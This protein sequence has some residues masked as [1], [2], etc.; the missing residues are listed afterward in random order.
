MEKLRRSQAFGLA[1]AGFEKIFV[2]GDNRV[3][4]RVDCRS[5]DRTIVHVPDGAFFR[6]AFL[7]IRRP[8]DFH[9]K[10]QTGDEPLKVVKPM[11]KF[12]IETRRISSRE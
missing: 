8:H 2:A 4:V 5:E 12:L 11:G 7:L 6:D 10:G 9:G 3:N 1:D